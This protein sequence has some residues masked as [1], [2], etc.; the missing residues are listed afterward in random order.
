MSLFPPLL[1]ILTFICPSLLEPQPHFSIFCFISP[2]PDIPFSRW[3]PHHILPFCFPGFCGNYKLKTPISEFVTRKCKCGRTNRI[4]C[5]LFVNFWHF[6]ERPLDFKDVL[7]Y[8]SQI[9]KTDEQFSMIA[10]NNF[11]VIYCLLSA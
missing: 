11:Y 10:L 9:I 2:K 6:T 3:I 1:C 7:I 4:C 8:I 5:Y